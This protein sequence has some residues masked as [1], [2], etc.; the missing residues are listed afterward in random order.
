MPTYQIKAPDG[1]TYQIDGPPNASKADVI[2]AVMRRNPSAGVAKVTHQIKAPDGNTYQIDGPKTAS[3]KEVAAA[4]IRQKPT[5]GKPP[6]PV[7]PTP[8]AAVEIGKRTKE[9][10]E[11]AASLN[12]M[13][14][15]TQ[16]LS[17]LPGATAS[18]REK[19]NVAVEEYRKTLANIANEKGY[20]QRT[21]TL[22]P[23]RSF[24]EIAT[25]T[26]KGL[27][28]G[29][30]R[31]VAGVPSFLGIAGIE[32]PGKASEQAAERFIQRNLAPDESDAA[33]FGTF[34]QQGRRLSEV[35]GSV[36]PAVLTR[37]A[38]RLGMLAGGARAVPA[39]TRVEQ[40]AQLALG[41]GPGAQQQRQAIEQ[42]E[43]ET[44][45]VVNPLVRA[46]AQAGGAAIGATEVLTLDAMMARVPSKLRG[47]MTSKLA[48]LVER[49]EVGGISPK[50]AAAEVRT[51]I[52]DI[53]KTGRGRVGV[54]M[55]EEGTQEG[56]A[57]FAQNVLEK[58]AYNS[59]K[60][61]TEGVAE[62]FIY[63][64]VVGGGVRGLTELVTKVTGGVETA[65]KI[66]SD[67]K[68]IAATMRLQE[69]PNDDAA[70]DTIVE[71]MVESYGITPEKAALYAQQ[72]LGRAREEGDTDVP[73]ADTG[74]DDFGGTDAGTASDIG[75]APSVSGA[76]DVGETVGGG[77]E[78]AVS[79]V[80]TPD[81]GEGARERPLIEP[82]AAQVKATVPT[83]E[84]AFEAS[85]LDFEEAYGSVLNKKNQLNAEQKKQ[86][87]RIILQSPEVDPYDAIGSVLDR[88][89]QL[90]GE[91]V[92]PRVSAAPT[93]EDI[94]AAKMA[95]PAAPPIDEV[96]VAPTKAAI[97]SVT[98]P[99]A[100][101]GPVPSL[102]Q[103][104]A[105]KLGITPTA[106]PEVAAPEVAAPEVAAPEVAPLSREE[107]PIYDPADYTP[108]EIYDN[109][110]R[111]GYKEAERRGYVFN[112][113]ENGMFGEGVREAK[114]PDIQPLTDE[115][116]LS[117]E[118]GSPEVLA[119]YKE[120]QQWGK[121]QVAAVQA[122]PVAEETALEAAPAPDVAVQEPVQGY[123]DTR[124]QELAAQ[125]AADVEAEANLRQEIEARKQ[126]EEEEA[127]PVAEEAALE[128]APVAEAAALEAAPV[129]EAAALEAAP[130]AEAAALEAA[131][132]VDPYA[133]VLADIEAA[134]AD[135]AIDARTHK[136]LTS[137]V[138]RRL[139]LE[140]IE[141]QLDVARTRSAERAMGSSNSERA[142]P[143]ERLQSL[144]YRMQDAWRVLTGKPILANARLADLLRDPD[145]L[146]KMNP[147][148]RGLAAALADVID[149]DVDVY[150]GN[151]NFSPQEAFILGTA[152][153]YDGAAPDVRLRGVST[154]ANIV[155]LLHEAVHI[156]L[157]AKFGS[158]FKRLT[159]LGPDADPE[160][161]ALRDEV[162]NLID[163]YN[164]MFEVESSTDL[165]LKASPY[166]MK[167]LDEFIAEGLTQPSFQKFL[168]K[169][170]LWTRFV[171]LVRKLLKLQPKFQPQLDNVLKAGAKLIA[172][173]KNIDRMED[174]GRTFEQRKK[175]APKGKGSAQ[176]RVATGEAEINRGVAQAQMAADMLEFT[177]GLSAAID[178][179]DGSFFLPSIKEG[180]ASFNDAT[181]EY[182]LPALTSSFI[183][184]DIDKGRLPPLRRMET[185]EANIRGAQ[186]R[187]R[188]QF[189][190]LD[191]R[192]TKFV[193]RTGQRVLATTMHA[194][195]INEFSP[196]D[197]SSLDNALQNDP[198]MVWYND[199]IKDPT[200]SKGQVAAF[201]GKK[202]IREKQIKAVWKLWEE[203]GKQKNGHDIYVRVR[204]FYA[205]MYT[206]MRTEQN[207]FIKKLPIDDAAKEELLV[208]VDPD[209]FAEG[210]ADP[211]D[212]HAG[213]PDSVRPKEYFP[214]RRYGK[215]WLTVKGD[216]IKTGRERHH[217]ET[218][219]G[220][221]A[222]LRKRAKELGVNPQDENI[223]EKGNTLEDFQNNLVESSLMLSNI[224]SVIDKAVI[225]GNY[226]TTK[227]ATPAEALEAMKKELR[228]KLYQTY[229]MTLPERSLRRQF[230]HAER[231]TGFSSDVLRNFRS[232]SAQ[233][234]VQIPK[235]Q[236]GSDVNSVISEG[237]DALEGMPVDE[238]AAAR[239]Y[240]DEMVQRL[241]GAINPEAPNAFVAGVSRFAFFEVMSS[242]ASAASQMLSVP[243]SVMPKLNA[244][245]GYT[246]AAAAFMRYSFIPYS[247]GLPERD[248][249]GMF[250]Q[251]MPSIGT[252]VAVKSN[253]IRARAF[254]EFTDRDL[255][256]SSA[257]SSLFLNNE[258]AH[259]YSSYNIPAE[260]LGLAFKAMRLP[261]TMFD[262]A[263]REMTAMMFFDLDY[264]KNRKDGMEPEEAYNTAIQ[265]T[266]NGL[267]ET[268]G[269][270]NLFE[271]P[272]YMVG[273]IRQLLFLFR[274]YA[275]N[276]TMFGL[277]MGI[278]TIRGE[279]A[280]GRTRAAAIHELGG[281]LAM[282]AILG[283]IA[284]APLLDVVC[285]AIDMI[286]PSLMDDEEEEEFRRQH[287]YSYNNSKHRFLY[288]WLP[289]N[290]GNP[291]LPG[292]DGKQHALADVLRNG[293]PSELIGVN[294]ASRVSWNGMWIRDSIPGENWSESIVNWLETNLSP[295]A[296]ISI[297]FIKAL[298]DVY[299]GD[300]MRGLEKIVPG[301]FRGSIT[302]ERLS[303]QGAE[304]RKGGKMFAKD[305]ITALQLNFQRMGWAPNEVSDW[306]RERMGALAMINAVTGERTDLMAKLNKAKS[307]PEGSSETVAEVEADI[308]E[309]NRLHPIPELQ[310][311]EEDIAK[312]RSRYLQSELDSYR[313]MQLTEEQKA[314][315]LKYK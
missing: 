311:E 281:N 307:D 41:A 151:L 256:D 55:L 160:M 272:R 314:I 76:A 26:L 2:A 211:N 119:A 10:D 30:L 262:V 123:V 175:A 260:V 64:A 28:A 231:V 315:M 57:Q 282:V 146:S 288:E 276:R 158:D 74:V 298:E 143:S 155:T 73:D 225:S 108:Q 168:E 90:R 120:G 1:N 279:N 56:T 38:S 33:Q 154:A 188:A 107:K 283:G 13:I 86:A 228:D 216:G 82:T 149:D 25:D 247:F 243:I 261:F 280:T 166:G 12:R 94:P 142:T 263:S 131:P 203:L 91:V 258:M 121:E 257:A 167:D 153:V 284:G 215:Y 259:T 50:A 207:S 32:S 209:N 173:S 72:Q 268:I 18:M 122:A 196:S 109:L 199:A 179:R 67:A 97:E 240:V 233:Y 156:A 68:L 43:A 303:T 208:A 227:Y 129:A 7:K 58:T 145:I 171:T 110:T 182:I 304:T 44:G 14:A 63:G 164:T 83:I 300:V 62:N 201:K 255:F 46:L 275:V 220:R 92:P 54:A 150:I 81:V 297:E 205:D 178:G 161:L 80:S 289:E 6:A 114:N 159:D 102:A 170:N 184:N 286:L 187:M 183:I 103:A 185:I 193:N 226:D 254:K 71:R 115:Q 148:Q 290:F 172:A 105:Q 181:R 111:F 238:K 17:K 265:N 141:A 230:I 177:D 244:D 162:Y 139:P 157:I 229:L 140:K 40:A 49:V 285:G 236:Y 99:A 266:V 248:A 163:A 210:E 37:G 5:A 313:G 213:I 253:P 165:L 299:K 27:G 197:F 47:S 312:S 85:A 287:P 223:F 189:G 118:R 180:W 138:E 174:V 293:I 192:F 124:K 20:M 77:L 34:A 195:R 31:T 224:F 222:F 42:Y 214:F 113:A 9:L 278:Q 130:V 277:R 19:A 23:E 144:I 136:L 219:F 190:K 125:E 237:Y 133:G 242:I 35:A 269:S 15:E 206:I 267:N 127:A 305:E 21:G 101:T 245:Y 104:S 235:L 88:G 39:I 217:F 70:F 306:Q 48:G 232:S 308:R 66:K 78:R 152:T 29:A 250:S 3:P 93:V 84:Q 176:E 294:F 69:N 61:V 221:N 194:A 274:M 132:E 52:A 126:Q 106:A 309:F 239:T 95:A 135:E 22:V 53:Q 310:I 24:G 137:A 134:L 60:D 79:G 98:A 128:A 186:N 292:L 198:I 36:A 296:A 246:A 100:D 112:T 59:E 87:A 147:A 212:P 65:N 117:L 204:D 200:V 251:V 202:T 301:T 4:V 96:A 249:D 270:H 252:S 51:L 8:K 302:A 264:G 218:A 271:R 116:V 295:G 89:L 191:R 11:S 16:R 169:G 291:T 45:K 273:Q 234:A 75:T 241:R